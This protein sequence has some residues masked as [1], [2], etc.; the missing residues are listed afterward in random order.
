MFGLLCCFWVVWLCLLVIVCV[1][2]FVVACVLDILLFGAWEGFACLL[3]ACAYCLVCFSELIALA[4]H[5][6]L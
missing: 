4:V 6:C 2:L 1:T 3:V 5:S